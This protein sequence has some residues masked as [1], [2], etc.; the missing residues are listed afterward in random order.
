MFWTSISGN[1]KLRP[2]GYGCWEQ[3]GRAVRF[4]LEYDTGTESLRTV[5]AKLDAY[6]SFL[7]DNFGILLFSVHSARREAGLRTALHRVLG[8]FDPGLVI[9]TTT[10]GM[11]HPDGPAGPVWALWTTR[12][13]DIVTERLRLADLPERGPRIAHRSSVIQPYNEAAFELNDPQVHDLFRT[14]RTRPVTPHSTGYSNQGLDP[15]HEDDNM[16]EIP[17]PDSNPR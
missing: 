4:F 2:D 1:D 8:T 14:R 6:Q 12:S 11:R 10:R 15:K 7:T 3:D 13:G 16:I 17:P 5:T 9:A